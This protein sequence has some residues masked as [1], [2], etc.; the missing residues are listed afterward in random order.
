MFVLVYGSVG[1]IGSQFI[2][3]LK[4]NNIRS[5][6]DLTFDIIIIYIKYDYSYCLLLITYCYNFIIILFFL[7][8]FLLCYFDCLLLLVAVKNSYKL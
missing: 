1:W 5:H 2:E 6:T 7:L 8:L 4:Q 3:L